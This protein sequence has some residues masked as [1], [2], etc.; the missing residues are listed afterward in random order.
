MDRSVRELVPE[1]MWADA[2][3]LNCM[4]HMH[5]EVTPTIRGGYNVGEVLTQQQKTKKVEE[6]VGHKENRAA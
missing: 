2:L 1:V 6:N 3:L 4:I 5:S